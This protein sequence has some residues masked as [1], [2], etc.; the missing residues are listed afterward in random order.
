MSRLVRTALAAA[1]ACT[2]G[3]AV[4]AD[5]APIDEPVATNDEALVFYTPKLP[6]PY[7]DFAPAW[8]KLCPSGQRA[9]RY[10]VQ[11]RFGPPLRSS[12]PTLG[13]RNGYWWGVNQF[14]TFDGTCS[15]R[16]YSASGAAQ[17]WD[18]LEPHAAT[19]LPIR[20]RE[21]DLLT[22]GPA[23]FRDCA[24]TAS[25]C[26]TGNCPA[27]GAYLYALGSRPH[28][29][30]D[31]CG[32]CGYVRGGYLYLTLPDYRSDTVQTVNLGGLTL[33]SS[34]DGVESASGNVLRVSP[35]GNQFMRISLATYAPSALDGPVLV[36]APPLTD[37]ELL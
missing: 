14:G 13:G 5:D 1:L 15:Y 18:A 32:S 8:A 10:S 11:L 6:I 2:V 33:L 30:V 24:A 7:I 19:A 31:P 35:R 21:G 9:Q 23:I 3:C 37:D 17:E 4:P 12:C 26:T 28:P 29:I 36:T 25:T 34:Q 16:W 22:E 20:Y 27:V